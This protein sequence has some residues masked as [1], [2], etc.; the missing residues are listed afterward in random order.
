MKQYQILNLTRQAR[1]WLSIRHLHWLIY[2]AL[3]TALLP[4]TAWFFSR[5]QSNSG[6]WLAWPLALVFEGGIFAFTHNLVSSIEKS[7]RLRQKEGEDWA[8]F[9][10]R[11]FTV[12]YLNASG[13]G[14]LGCSTVSGLANFSYAVTFS[15]PLDVYGIP[16]PLFEILSGGVLPFIGLIF[17]RV[18]ANTA[19]EHQADDAEAKL[20]AELRRANKSVEKLRQTVENLRLSQAETEQAAKTT[21]HKLQQLQAAAKFTELTH[22]STEVRVKAAKR[23]WPDVTQATLAEIAG[24]SPSYTSQ[25]LNRNGKGE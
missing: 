2:I 1:A 9:V 8:T 24:A 10:W 16:M 7:S 5:F 19:D 12:G 6:A 25:V 17:A 18:L 20:K 15:Q 4:H 13:V 21:E 3:L 22:D 14:L 11:K 23:L